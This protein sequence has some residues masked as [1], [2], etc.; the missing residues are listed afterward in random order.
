MK[1]EIKK[2]KKQIDFLNQII[3][4]LNKE[5]DEYKIIILDLQDQINYLEEE[6]NEEKCNKYI[7]KEN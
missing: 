5:I 2:L 4:G 3:S 7:E 1:D 6:L